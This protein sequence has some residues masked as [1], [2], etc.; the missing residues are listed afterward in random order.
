MSNLE[1]MGGGGG[2]GGGW[3]KMVRILSN[4]E[5]TSVPQGSI[6]GPL[7]FL[8]YSNDM[9]KCLKSTTPCLYADDTEI[10]ASSFDYDIIIII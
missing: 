1:F 5:T 4:K 3:T 6:F 9:P 7:L 2:G 10:F 8:L